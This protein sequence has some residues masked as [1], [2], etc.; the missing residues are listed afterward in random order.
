MK[1]KSA[2]FAA[3]DLVRV[4]DIPLDELLTHL[5]GAILRAEEAD[6]I[7]LDGALAALQRKIA[8]RLV[9]APL[10]RAGH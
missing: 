1:L 9:V 3:A 5:L 6:L 4:P 2:T 10:G 8:E 7:S